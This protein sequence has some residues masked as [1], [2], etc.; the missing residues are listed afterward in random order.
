MTEFNI[1]IK[2]NAVQIK[3]IK[4]KADTIEIIGRSTILIDDKIQVDFDMEIIE[5]Y[6]N[7]FK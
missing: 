2:Y 5:F 7:Q 1:D 6:A 3:T 4:V